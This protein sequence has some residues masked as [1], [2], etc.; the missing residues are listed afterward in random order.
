RGARKTLP[1]DAAKA[2]LPA[3]LDRVFEE[4]N[5]PVVAALGSVFGGLG[6]MT[7]Q[8]GGEVV[9]TVN[10]NGRL[11][12]S[13]MEQMR[14]RALLGDRL[15][16]AQMLDVWRPVL[17]EDRGHKEYAVM[18]ARDAQHVIDEKPTTAALTTKALAL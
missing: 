13:Q 16:P 15:T 12:A 2:D 4:G 1:A 11:L 18:A 10:L 7:A 9:Q 8:A 3:G 17:Q 6:H 14:L 5:H